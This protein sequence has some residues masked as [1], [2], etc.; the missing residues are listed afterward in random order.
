ML[1]NQKLLTLSIVTLGAFF[2]F[3]VLM[4]YKEWMAINNTKNQ[5]VEN[6]S[7][8][9]SL[10]PLTQYSLRDQSIIIP[11]DTSVTPIVPEKIRINVTV[12]NTFSKPLWGKGANCNYHGLIE[13]KTLTGWTIATEERCPEE[14]QPLPGRLFK[15]KVDE[16]TLHLLTEDAKGMYR[17]RLDLLYDCTATEDMNNEIH[18]NNCQRE[19][20]SYSP[21]FTIVN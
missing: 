21:T 12:L 3:V 19:A 7:D 6:I 16:L 15:N 13:K 11:A 14:Q 10:S 17:I 18:Y 1:K 20:V 4:Y 5:S 8:Q 2:T 9:L